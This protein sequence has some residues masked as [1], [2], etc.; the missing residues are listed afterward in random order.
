MAHPLQLLSP[1]Y[2]MYVLRAEGPHHHSLGRRPRRQAF[3]LR[4]AGLALT[5]AVVGCMLS[6]AQMQLPPGTSSSV[7]GTERQ[8]APSAETAALQKAEDAISAGKYAEAVADLQPLATSTQKNEH[9][10]YDLGFAQDA[11]GH[12]AEAQEAYRAALAFNPNDASARVSLGL[13]LARG[14][15]R[16]GAEEQLAAAVK[17]P[18]AHPELLARAYRALAQIDL[19]TKPEQARDE[20]LEGLKRSPETPEDAA[21][22]AEIADTLH[23]DA[24]AEKAY[25]H[26]QQ[27]AP[28]D[29]EVALGYAR[30]LSREK[31]YTEAEAALEPARKAHPESRELLAEFASQ[32]LLLGKTT[33]ALPM[34]EQLHAARPDDAPLARLLATAYVTGGTP[35]KAN[36]IYEA[37]LKDHPEDA[38]LQVDWADCLIRQQR[39]AEA[40]P[41]L[42]RVLSK[43]GD[44]VSRDLR[45]N[46]AGMLAFAASKNGE[47]ATVLEALSK[48]EQLAPATAPYTFLA[49]TAHDRLHHTKQ[50]AEQYRLFIEQAGG[51]FPDQEWQARQRLHILDRSK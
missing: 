39:S 2:R 15:D 1:F 20:L 44:A 18:G 23:D 38:H 11:L 50:A 28:A 13:L 3:L 37:L 35:S 9:I 49:A 21:L 47:P 25:A 34:L 30:L 24:A 10:F 12:D 27:M 8:A 4:P 5:L 7:P 42:L 51:R 41:I 31:K 43:T 14:T 6:S 17:I 45:A 36:P 32:E 16:T 29:P 40:E 22:A 19:E 26:A 48:R 46:A 33:E